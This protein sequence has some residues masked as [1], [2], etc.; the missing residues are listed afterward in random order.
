MTGK[1]RVHFGGAFYQVTARGNQGAKV[2]KSAPDYKLYLRLLKDYQKPYPFLPYAYFLMPTQW[3]P[4]FDRFTGFQASGSA[5][6]F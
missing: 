5:G 2:F 1:A 4:L 6:G 3:L